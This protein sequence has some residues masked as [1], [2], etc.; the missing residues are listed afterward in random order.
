MPSSQSNPAA[1]LAAPAGWSRRAAGLGLA[2]IALLLLAATAARAERSVSVARLAW[3]TG[4]WELTSG[5]RMVEEAWMAP[6]GRTLMG[7]ARTTRADSL[8][9]F[10]F[11]QIVE[12]S[13][14]LVFVA[15]PARQPPASF[16]STLLTDSMVVFE[17]LEHDFPQRVSYQRTADGSLIARIEGTS[18]GK[19][20]AVDFP[21]RPV[22]CP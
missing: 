3:L 9:D 20:R 6:R 10:E 13:A 19:P 14:A 22:R 17:N 7:M 11:L 4:C 18:K 12:D 8:V 5:T 2:G 16:R 15:R 1:R 21:Y